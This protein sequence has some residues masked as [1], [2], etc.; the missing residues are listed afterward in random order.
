MYQFLIAA[1]Y[2]IAAALNLHTAVENRRRREREQSE[3]S[4]VRGR[5]EHPKH[6]RKD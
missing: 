6:L 4:E 3:N 2:V 5:R 1:M